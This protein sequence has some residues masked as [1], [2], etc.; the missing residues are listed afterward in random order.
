MLILGTLLTVGVDGATTALC[1]TS[2]ASLESAAETTQAREES[3]TDPAIGV[4]DRL[5]QGLGIA[6]PMATFSMRG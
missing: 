1:P 4:D 5:Q 3:L 6:N 2:A